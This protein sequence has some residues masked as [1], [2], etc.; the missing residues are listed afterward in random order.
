MSVPN[1]SHNHYRQQ[2]PPEETVKFLAP[3]KLKSSLQRLANERNIS[4]SALMRLISSEYVKR[5]NTT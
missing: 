1:T 5:H 4:L 2:L 3:H